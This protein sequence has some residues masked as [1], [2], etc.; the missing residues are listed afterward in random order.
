MQIET[1]HPLTA[2]TRRQR[3]TDEKSGPKLIRQL[4]WFHSFTLDHTRLPERSPLSRKHPYANL[5]ICGGG[6]ASAPLA[7]CVG[8]DAD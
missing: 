4:S 2:Q 3:I 8:S 7:Q 5:A 6:V 1:S